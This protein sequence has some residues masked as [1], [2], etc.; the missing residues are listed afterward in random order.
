M[1]TLSQMEENMK[2][3][4]K[5]IQSTI[6]AGFMLALTMTATKQEGKP[7]SIK[8]PKNVAVAQV[9]PEL[10]ITKEKRNTV[11]VASSAET[12][13]IMEE[14]QQP[15]VTSEAIPNTEE[16]QQPVIASEA[17]PSVEE[18]KTVSSEWATKLVPNVEIYLNIRKEAD[19]ESD[20]V[21]KLYSDGAAEILE[22]GDEWTK[23]SSGS[24]EG[25]VK[26]EFC[27]FDAEAEKRAQEVGTVYATSL[28]GGLRVRQEANTTEETKILTV[29]E[30]GEKI[31]VDTETEA[32]EGWTVVKGS[33]FTGYVSSEY[34]SVELKMAKAISIEEELAAIK[35]AEEAQKAKEAASATTQQTSSQSQQ[36]QSPGVSQKEAIVSSYDDVTLL[37]ALIQCEA[38]GEGYDGQLAVGA[39]VMNRLRS[40]WAGSIADVIYQKHQFSPA[41]SGKLAKVLANGVNGSC[42]AAA[43]EAI[44]GADNVD[45]AVYFKHA[46]SGHAGI[47]IGNI[48]FHK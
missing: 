15:I 14:T 12:T 16:T 23:I 9:E 31:K 18:E 13:P 37:G 41:G 45:G 34:V 4:S 19:A 28:T 38:G 8:Q 25:Y 35:A 43:Q 29:L 2:F 32:P 3:N 22:R 24:V 6:V 1:A 20:L 27:F 48:V 10:T 21:G 26:N 17:A 30:E 33:D 5:V 44:N 42:L 39:V 36:T 40:G 11:V 7:V 47:V 46:S